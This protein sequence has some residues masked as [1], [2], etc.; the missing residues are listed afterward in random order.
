METF[1]MDDSLAWEK[2]GGTPHPKGKMRESLVTL[3]RYF[4]VTIKNTKTVSKLGLGSL[5]RDTS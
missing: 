1:G 4:G 5:N 2:G 3:R